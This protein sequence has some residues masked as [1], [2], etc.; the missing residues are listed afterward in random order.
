MVTH[1]KILNM[2]FYIKFCCTAVPGV[3]YKLA[4]G[5]YYNDKFNCPEIDIPVQYLV[6]TIFRIS[7]VSQTKV[8]KPRIITETAGDETG[9]G[10]IFWQGPPK[11]FGLSLFPNN[12]WQ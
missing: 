2:V 5:H 10:A 4:V 9:P 11:M 8:T 12:K 3:P 1:G 7:S 6:Y